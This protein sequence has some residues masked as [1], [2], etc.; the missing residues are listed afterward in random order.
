M[1]TAQPP[2]PARLPLL[3]ALRGIAAIGVVLHHEPLLYG[4]AGPFTR[5]YLAV[6]FFFM[7]SGLVLTLAFEPKLRAGLG[8]RR[9]L[10]GRLARLWPILAAGV[11]IG[12]AGFWW[13]YGPAH[14]PAL[15]LASLML[16][17]L[18]LGRG[19]LFRL[20]GP[21]WSVSYEV[22]ANAV[23]ALLLWR[24]SNRALLGF[25]LACGG[26]LAWQA[27]HWGSVGMGD[28]T[29]NWWGGFARVGYGYGLGV[30]LGRQHAAGRGRIA[31]WAAWGA[32]TLLPLALFTAKWW[33]LPTLAGDLLAVFIL[34]PP[35]LWGAAQVAM[36]GWPARVADGLGRLSY[37]VYAVHGPV[38]IWGAMLGRA[39]GAWAGA[40]RPATLVLT[41]ALGALL[42]ISPLARGI[43]LRRQ[44]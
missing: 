35:A 27:A 29:P 44:G 24:L 13:H 38:L 41:F 26:V 28:A 31:P 4:A 18:P 36:A 5:A 3:D 11:G 20:D 37:P 42:A 14:L 22:L 21:Q 19:G 12:A 23:H 1:H 9:F 17:P 33:P 16:L 43:P 40:L 15:L 10:L 32:A 7:L 34:F 2:R 6:D 8:A 30:W 39:H 25:A